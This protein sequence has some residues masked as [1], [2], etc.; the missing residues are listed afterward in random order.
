[1]QEVQYDWKKSELNAMEILNKELWYP[2][3]NF[4]K[5]FN[6][7][8]D[9]GKGIFSSENIDEWL[10]VVSKLPF[11]YSIV[12]LP[13]QKW[14]DRWPRIAMECSFW[15]FSLSNI[16]LSSK[17]TNSTYPEREKLNKSDIIVGD[18]NMTPS[19][20]EKIKSE[21]I[22]SYDIERYVSYPSEG[23][24]FDYCLIRHWKFIRIET[25]EWL[26]DHAWLYF[27]IEL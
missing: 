24:T 19:E 16:H 5:C 11:D 26:S 7:S 14:I 2:Y 9:Y 22:S 15:N 27:E 3:Q 12:E 23:N 20:L 13:I 18:F 8:Q 4:A 1:M 10:A 25:F 6:Y 21:Y 17:W